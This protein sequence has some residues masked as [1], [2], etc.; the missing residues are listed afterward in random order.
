[1]I[2]GI[3]GGALPTSLTFTPNAGSPVVATLVVGSLIADARYGFIYQA[4]VP[5]GT[6]TDVT[7]AFA[8][9]PFAN[10]EYALYSADGA[11]MNS[12][13][14]TDSK[15]TSGASGTASLTVNL[16]A[17]AGGFILACAS[18]GDLTNPTTTWSG[19]ESYTRRSD[20]TGNAQRASFADASNITGSATDAVTASWSLSASNVQLTSAVW[21]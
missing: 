6:T 13:T 10:F 20:V 16:N 21:R 12:T 11:Q 17:S 18:Y 4:N 1:M 2:V 15:K 8:F 14:A 7:F 5:T 9:N 3:G 19:G